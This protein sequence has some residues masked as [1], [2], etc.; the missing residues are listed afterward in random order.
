MNLRVR[1]RESREKKSAA[2]RVLLPRIA[3]AST[4]LEAVAVGVV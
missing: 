4:Q 3:D 1:K 2:L